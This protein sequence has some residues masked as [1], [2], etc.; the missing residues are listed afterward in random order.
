MNVLTKYIVVEIL[1]ASLVAILVLMSLY[2]ILAFAHEM[3]DLGK[4]DYGLK[5]IILYLLLTTPKAVYQLM[6]SAALLASLV[7]L[8][9]MVSNHE[10]VAM[11]VATFSIV[12]I[13]KAVVLAAVVLVMLST[14]INEF[15][16]PI[17]EHT[18]HTIK[19][20]S[21]KKEVLSGDI[22]GFWLRD[23]N[24]YINVQ[25]M[26]GYGKL[27]DIILYELNEHSVHTIK[28]VRRATYVE[29][30]HLLLEDVAQTKISK[31]K[32]IADKFD[33]MTWET[34]ID[35][36]S[37]NTDV[38][39]ISTEDLSTYN[40]FKRMQILKNKDKESPALALVFWNRLADP[41]VIVMMLLVA[42]PIVIKE[43]RGFGIGSRIIVGALFGV[44]FHLFSKIVGHAGLVYG[45]DPMFVGIFPS[46]VITIIAI[47]VI[48]KLR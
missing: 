21:L 11:R 42:V 34:I 35:Q 20:K 19:T 15:V 33:K 5:Q 27:A 36:D 25:Q 41:L 37:L 23:K 10:L 18:A 14:T 7:V 43:N 13:V 8:G 38:G 26:L 45:Y 12:A 48:A 31:N 3:G 17:A 1:K 4:E 9:A 44:G 2:N 39:L 16:V 28:Y 30:K 6:P 24:T 47:S 29:S 40:L 22:R 46:M 32:A